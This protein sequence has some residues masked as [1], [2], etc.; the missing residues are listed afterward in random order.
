MEVKHIE[1]TQGKYAIVDAALAYDYMA[2]KHY[3]EFAKTN[4]LR[5]KS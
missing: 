1:L 5:K 4:I 3:G 2:I